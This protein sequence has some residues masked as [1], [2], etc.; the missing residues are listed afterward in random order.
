M[1]VRA[2]INDI[3]NRKTIE[4]MERTKGWLSETINKI[5]KPLDRLTKKKKTE[6]TQINKIINKIFE[7]YTLVRKHF[8]SYVIGDNINGWSLLRATGGVYLQFK[9]TDASNP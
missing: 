9:C 3:E 8:V 6:R 1:K 4:N 5:G 7:F 2:E